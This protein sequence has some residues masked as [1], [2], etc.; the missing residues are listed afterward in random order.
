M[1]PQL[2]KY[3]EDLVGA[4]RFEL[5]ISSTQ[6]RRLTACLHPAELISRLGHPATV[7]IDP[8][9]KWFPRLNRL[10]AGGRMIA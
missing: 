3:R 7:T 4:G 8:G 2:K 5:P 1:T 10:Q 6:E 9:M